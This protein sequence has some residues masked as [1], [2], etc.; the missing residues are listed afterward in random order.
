MDAQLIALGVQLL[1]SVLTSAKVQGAAVETITAIGDAIDRL[2]QVQGAAT[3][4][5]ELEALRSQKEF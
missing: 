5:A 3:T 1:T 2:L 4:Y